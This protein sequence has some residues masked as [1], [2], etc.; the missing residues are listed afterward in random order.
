MVHYFRFEVGVRVEGF[1][2]GGE[3]RHINSGF[4]TFRPQDDDVILPNLVTDTQVGEE[5]AANA[6]A[7]HYLWLDR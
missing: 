7:R 5:R 3:S 2:V 4:F 1:A 6:V